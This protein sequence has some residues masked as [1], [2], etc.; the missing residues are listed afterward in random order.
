MFEIIIYRF[1]L[2]K[3]I[4]VCLRDLLATAGI[5]GHLLYLQYEDISLQYEEK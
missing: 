2:H 1:Y 3:G 5:I 4:Y